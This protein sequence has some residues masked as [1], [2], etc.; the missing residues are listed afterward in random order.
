VFEHLDDLGAIRCAVADILVLASSGQC[1]ADRVKAV[2][3]LLEQAV[4]AL[5]CEEIV[6]R[7]ER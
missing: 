1:Q 7:Q 2:R 4:E 3:K 6:E 5:H